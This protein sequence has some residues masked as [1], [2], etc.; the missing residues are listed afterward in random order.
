MNYLTFKKDLQ[1]LFRL[2]LS[3]EKRQKITAQSKELK[4]NLEKVKTSTVILKFKA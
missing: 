2:K 3:K 4:L 1:N